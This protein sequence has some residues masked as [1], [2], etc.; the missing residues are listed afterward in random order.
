[1]WQN[2]DLIFHQKVVDGQEGV[3]SH[4]CAEEPTLPVSTIQNDDDKRSSTKV[5]EHFCKIVG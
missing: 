3:A 1:M 2:S 4:C 5:A